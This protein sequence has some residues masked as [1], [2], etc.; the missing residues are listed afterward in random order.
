MFS[1]KRLTSPWGFSLELQTWCLWLLGLPSPGQHSSQRWSQAIPN[2][3]AGGPQGN[4]WPWN[5]GEAGTRGGLE[6]N[7][8]NSKGSFSCSF[9]A[10]PIFKRKDRTRINKAWFWR[11]FS[12][13][14]SVLWRGRELSVRQRALH[15][16][17]TAV[18]WLQRLWRLERRGSLQYVSGRAGVL[19]GPGGHCTV[20]SWP[21]RQMLQPLQFAWLMGQHCARTPCPGLSS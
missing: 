2:E 11:C 19:C 21:P 13:P 1:P 10:A 6:T 9:F 16:R 20:L 17:E 5:W 4:W 7:L 18:Q 14:F 15:P 3:G 8:L 12:P